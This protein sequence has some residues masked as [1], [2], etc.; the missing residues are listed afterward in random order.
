MQQHGAERMGAPATAAVFRVLAPAEQLA[1]REGQFSGCCGAFAA[2]TCRVDVP[3]L[4]AAVTCCSYGDGYEIDWPT[5]IVLLVRLFSAI[6]SE[7][8]VL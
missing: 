2:V 8:V 4:C 7:T 3:R 1:L 5:R 6:N